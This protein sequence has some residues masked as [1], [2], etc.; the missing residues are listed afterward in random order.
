MFWIGLNIATTA[1]Y[2]VGGSSG[3]EEK[4][5]NE[6]PRPEPPPPPLTRDQVLG[7]PRILV[8]VDGMREPAIPPRPTPPRRRR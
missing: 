3:R 1:L 4:A 2:F 5:R 8:A 6:R 7:S